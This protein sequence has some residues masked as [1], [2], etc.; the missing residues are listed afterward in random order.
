MTSNGLCY[1]EGLWQDPA[2]SPSGRPL[3]RAL[4]RFMVDRAHIPNGDCKRPEP[5]KPEWLRR[6]DRGLL[7]AKELTR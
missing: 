4:P 5:V 3:G 7:R 1:C 6:K 2:R